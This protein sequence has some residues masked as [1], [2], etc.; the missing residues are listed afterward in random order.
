MHRIKYVNLLLYILISVLFVSGCS[1]SAASYNY[2]SAYAQFN[3]GN[4]EE[5]KKFIDKVIYKD[6]DSKKGAFNN[7]LKAEYLVLAG[8]IYMEVPEYDKAIMQFDKV[9]S[10]SKKIADLEN[11]KE[12]CRGKGLVYARQG[13]YVKAIEEYNKALE[14]NVNESLNKD[15]DKYKIEATIYNNQNEEALALCDAYLKKY[16]KDEG[17]DLLKAK[18][19]AY[20]KN[21]EQMV[22]CMDTVIKK[23]NN[24]AYYYLAQCYMQLGNYAKA[25][26]N[27]EIYSKKATGVDKKLLALAILECLVKQENYDKA[28]ELVK[29]YDKGEKDDYDRE[30]RQYH[31]TILE[32]QG[33]YSEACAKAKEYIAVYT[34]DEAMKKEVAFL[35]T[36]IVE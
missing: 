27:Y 29:L 36:R 2:E 7:D 10:N 30:F 1:F 16:G 21:E 8:H 11:N 22:A 9:I 32:K 12:A 14:I 34:D 23:G 28:L 33:N 35:E 20:V 19:Y 6:G 4:Y 13:D 31:I 26:E 17:I 3:K 25:Y 5:A 24:N 15:I 18:S